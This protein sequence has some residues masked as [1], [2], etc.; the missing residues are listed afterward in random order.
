[1]EKGKMSPPGIEP[2]FWW[3]LTLVA[4]FFWHSSALVQWLSGGM[5][6]QGPIGR[7]S[8]DLGW[9]RYTPSAT[10]AQTTAAYSLDYSI[11]LPVPACI[12][13]ICLLFLRGG[14]NYI[15]SFRQ[16]CFS[17]IS[18]TQILQELLIAWCLGSY[19]NLV[20]RLDC[21]LRPANQNVKFVATNHKAQGLR[22]TMPLCLRAAPKSGTIIKFHWFSLHL[23]L[24][25]ILSWF[26]S[27]TQSSWRVSTAKRARASSLFVTT[28]SAT[29]RFCSNVVLFNFWVIVQLNYPDWSE[30]ARAQTINHLL[31]FWN[32]I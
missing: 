32:Q 12:K 4:L 17:G 29:C 22:E 28:F 7:L 19:G 26:R 23:S 10:F 8:W 30:C 20:K 1:M 14:G 5:Y 3:R 15:F 18:V 13:N 31:C 11:A 24:I 27:T 9:T 2:S 6:P 21:W 16:L 25:M